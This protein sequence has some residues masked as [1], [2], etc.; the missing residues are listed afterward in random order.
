[1]GQNKKDEYNTETTSKEK[2]ERRET[3][4]KCA[5]QENG[6]TKE[7]REKKKKKKKRKSN[8][9]KGHG[10]EWTQVNLSQIM[11]EMYQCPPL[12]MA[13][14]CLSVPFMIGTC[15]R[16]NGRSGKVGMLWH[17]R[18]ENRPLIRYGR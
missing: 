6:E 16:R 14:D 13:S 1:V 7:K 17:V 18:S 2:Q 3:K 15:D 12:F 10:W 5:K 4:E 8:D 11:H 9:H